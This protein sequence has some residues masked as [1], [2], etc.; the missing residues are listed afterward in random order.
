MKEM[1]GP[2]CVQCKYG[3]IHI[4]YH[5]DKTSLRIDVTLQGKYKQISGLPVIVYRSFIYFPLNDS[6]KFFESALKMNVRLLEKKLDECF[7]QE[8]DRGMRL[9]DFRLI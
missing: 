2:K 3:P 6:D 7:V 8:F 5:K 9:G 4:G 1:I